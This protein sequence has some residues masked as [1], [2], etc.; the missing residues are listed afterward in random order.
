M[1]T[2]ELNNPQLPDLMGTNASELFGWDEL[3][4]LDLKLGDIVHMKAA[5]ITGYGITGVVVRVTPQQVVVEIAKL[6]YPV[7]DETAFGR[8]AN[9]EKPNEVEFLKEIEEVRK[10]KHLRFWKLSGH[11]IGGNRSLVKS[12]AQ[13]FKGELGNVLNQ[14]K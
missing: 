8:I 2:L 10:G 6:W 9:H 1:K 13:L 7:F 14:H 4:G 3:S 11:E 12:S 5:R